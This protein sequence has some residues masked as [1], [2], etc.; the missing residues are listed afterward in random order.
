MREKKEEKS[1]AIKLDRNSLMAALR[2]GR[3]NFRNEDLSGL[4]LTRARLTNANL[5]GANLTGAKLWRANLTGANLTGADL[6]CAN[7]TGANLTRTSLDR[8]GL[9]VQYAMGRRD[10]RGVSLYSVDL[11]G[12]D[13]T[14]ADLTGADLRFAGL[15]QANLTGANLTRARLT[16]A[17]L[18][19]ANLVFV[20]GLQDDEKRVAQVNKQS[21]RRVVG[22]LSILNATPLLQ[23]LSAIVVSFLGATSQMHKNALFLIAFQKHYRPSMFHS[24]TG[25]IWG[26]N[27]RVLFQSSSP[28]RD[29][30]NHDGDNTQ[31]AL[32]LIAE[33]GGNRQAALLRDRRGK[34]Y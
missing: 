23:D 34:V 22:L 4:D 6:R 27:L 3:T 29:A 31:V 25:G 1:S 18:T 11:S 17:N 14:G 21:H 8:A 9:H 30:K 33:N 24:V 2:E 20:T 12:L 16:N 5:R 10:F 19:R 32:A 13:L 15:V 28:E 7:L 26:P